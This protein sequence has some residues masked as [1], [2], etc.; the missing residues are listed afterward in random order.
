MEKVLNQEEI[1]ALVRAARSGSQDLP[2]QQE[3]I[4]RWDV[5]QAGQ[6]GREQLKAITQL[7]EGFARNLTHSL[8]AYLRVVFTATLVSAEHLTYREFLQRIPEMTYIAACRLEPMGVNAALQL[9]LKVAFPIIDLLLGGEGKTMP[10]SREITEIEEEILDSVARIVCREL[11]AAWQTLSL[12]A[13]FEEHLDTGSAQ[14]LMAPEEKILSLSFEIEMPEIRGGLNLAIPV[15]VSNALLR[16]ISDS[17]NHHR[18]RTSSDVRARMMRQLLQCHFVAELGAT[19][20]RISLGTL[21]R[22]SVGDMITFSRNTGVPASLSIE[23][24]EIRAALPARCG[25]RRAARLPNEPLKNPHGQV[26]GGRN[27]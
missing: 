13:S 6:I 12:D 27:E 19:E 4:D 1:D 3:H 10:A 15:T 9:D 25:A 21:A 5:R 7:H 18:S 22:L 17:W 11:G 14:R 2:A 8:G 20:M 23:G 24:Y 16:K 26:S